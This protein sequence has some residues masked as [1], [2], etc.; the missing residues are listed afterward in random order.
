[1]SYTPPTNSPTE[2]DKTRVQKVVTQFA[3]AWKARGTT[4]EEIY[5]SAFLPPAEDR[6][7]VLMLHQLLPTD[8]A[9]RWNR[10]EKPLIESYLESFP[11]LGTAND[12]P[13]D[14]IC[15]EFRIR[16]RHGDNPKLEG[17]QKRFPRQFSGLRALINQT[18]NASTTHPLFDTPLPAPE[19]PRAELR[20]PENRKVVTG[21]EGYE[22]LECIGHGA[23]ADVWKAEAPG[24]IEVA[25]KIIRWTASN[26]LSQV[27]LRA[28]ELIKR[29]RHAFLLQVQAYWLSEGQL[30]VVMDLADGTLQHRMEACQREGLPGIPTRELLSYLREVAEALDFLHAN[31]VLHRDIKPANI[32]LASGHAKLAD[33]GLARLVIEKGTDIRATTTGTPLYM[34]PE[35]WGNK[36]GPESDQYSLASTYVE[37]R[38]GRP[39][40][41]AETYTDVML[42][43]LNTRPKLDEL[44]ANE[45]RV[46]QKALSKQIENRYANCLAFVAALEEAVELDTNPPKSFARR[47]LLAALLF[48]TLAAGLGFAAQQWWPWRTRE[49]SAPSQLQVV[50]GDEATFELH[51]L[52]ATASSN[53]QPVF[54]GVP[55]GVRLEATSVDDASADSRVWRV[56]VHSDLNSPESVFEQPHEISV[57]LADGDQQLLDSIQLT[58]KPPVMILPAGCAPAPQATRVHV[59]SEK[60]NYWNRIVRQLPGKSLP[61]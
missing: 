56:Q 28:L 24:G 41:P 34:S 17:Y 19:V 47:Y 35:V 27:E 20:S 2:L 8:L 12:L 21:G 9:F 29:L 51:L 52:G 42:D 14:L 3:E 7:R 45:Q 53:S 6:L 57:A 44:P 22:L 55:A 16:T 23:F 48:L 49:L 31:Q 54:T 25:V 38:L 58:L 15:D 37:L 13:V 1:M 59:E 30:Y 5:L 36:V 32:M 39:L 46:L 40:F 43:H 60:K 10:G 11:E 18:L 26:K 50:A 33:F 61:A 4:N